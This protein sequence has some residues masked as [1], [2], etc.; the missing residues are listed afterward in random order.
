MPAL[1]KATTAEQA[2][3]LI[4]EKL[5]IADPEH[6]QTLSDCLTDVGL[7]DPYRRA[8]ALRLLRAKLRPPLG[9]HAHLTLEQRW[10]YERERWAKETGLHKGKVTGQFDPETDTTRA[11][12]RALDDSEYLPETARG[13]V[14]TIRQQLAF[15]ANKKLNE[16]SAELIGD[17]VQELMH[18]MEVQGRLL[19]EEGGP[20]PTSRA[21]RR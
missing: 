20:N 21:A 18:E 9:S 4:L 10:A 3:E 8:L 12:V 11:L 19:E 15:R 5:T 17:S 2:V 13:A 14:G 7:F 1:V 6:P 16:T